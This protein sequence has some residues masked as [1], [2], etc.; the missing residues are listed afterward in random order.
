MNES[1]FIFKNKISLEGFSEWISPSNIA[2]IKYWGKQKNQIPKNPSLSFTLSKSTTKTKV[3]YG[4][5]LNYKD[6]FS[7]DFLFNGK[8]EPS[9][10]PK[11]EM[12]LNRIVRY[13]P[14]IKNHHFKIESQNSFPHSSGIASSA[15][16][17]SSISLGILEVERKYNT[18][19]TRDFFLKKASFLARLGSGSASRSIYGPISVWGKNSSYKDSSDYYAVDIGNRVNKVFLKYQN[20]ILLVYKSK[21]KISSTK[22][23]ELMETNPY[24]FERFNQAKKNL[25]E[26]KKALSSGDIDNFIKIVESEALS[27]HGLMLTSNPY[28]IL[29][30]PETLSIINKIWDFRNETKCPICFTLDAG[31]NVH[32]LYPIEYKKIALKFIK[33]NLLVFC[34]NGKYI[35]DMVGLGSKKNK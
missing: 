6:D 16:S 17:M 32:L 1:D 30:K 7:L 18:S 33:E 4:P 27:L 28:F 15:S 2:L 19:M 29:F 35:N 13:I 10:V 11:I 12:F 8:P 24:A 5:R 22:G 23:H 34:Q 14:Y 3:T 21:K 9:F 25:K 31:A 26:F 20:T